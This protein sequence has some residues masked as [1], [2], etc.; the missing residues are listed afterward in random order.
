MLDAI[1]KQAADVSTL[2]FE[3][4]D[5]VSRNLSNMNTYGYKGYRF[6]M[7]ITPEQTVQTMAPK[8]MAPG[9]NMITKRE[10]D[11]AV[12]GQGFIQ[13]TRPDGQSAYTRFGSLEVN[14][15]GYLVTPYGD[16]IG[17]GIKLPTNYEKVRIERDGTVK[18]TD[19]PG[20]TPRTMGKI[21]MVNFPNPAGL[22]NIGYNAYV[23]TAE[24]GTPVRAAEDTELHQ[25]YLERSNVDVQYSVNEILR[26][27]AG[28]L[29]N[30]RIV[31]FIDQLYQ[32]AVNL[33]Q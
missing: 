5:Y 3:Y 30:L 23:E 13:I 27:N 11:V 6:Q 24:S 15:Q 1:L 9:T 4:L 17:T 29:T 32:E 12:D 10:L 7:Y 18:L 25:G 26:L 2:H 33:R 16:M 19:K 14:N 31:K 21:P 28:A 22:R 8:D 20:D